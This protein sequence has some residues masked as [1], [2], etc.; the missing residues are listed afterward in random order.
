MPAGV[1][2]FCKKLRYELGRRDSSGFWK[3]KKAD[4]LANTA[5]ENG[6]QTRRV[7]KS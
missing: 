1:E 6:R 2:Y 3:Q 5:Q 7:A 4:Y